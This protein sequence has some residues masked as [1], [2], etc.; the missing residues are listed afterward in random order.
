MSYN[1]TVTKSHRF[2]P[3]TEQAKEFGQISE[4]L[5]RKLATCQQAAPYWV[6]M[7]KAWLVCLYKAQIT[8]K[9]TSEK[10]LTALDKLEGIP[11]Y[12]TE[13]RL[14]DGL[15]MDEKTASVV[16]IGRT[17]QEPMSRLQLRDCLI[18]AFDDLS[19]L[20]KTVIEVAE[21]NIDTI[22]PG[23]THLSHAQPITFAHYLL[24]IFDALQRG[25][26]A[27]ALAYRDTNRNSGGCGACSGIAWPVDRRLMSNL[28][29]FDELLEPTYDSEASQDHSM[30]ILFALANISLLISKSSMDINIWGM[31]EIDFF[32]TS[33]EWCGCSSMMPQKCIP[34]SQ[35]ER[36][37]IQTS[38]VV[39]ELNTGI[40][41]SKGEPHGDML[42]ICRVWGAAL[43]GIFYTQAAIGY[44]KGVLSN[45]TPQKEK[46]LESV[47]EGYSCATELV[48]H[49]VKN[50]G[51]GGRGAHRIVATMVR[52]GREKGLKAYE[53][54]GELLDEAARFSEDKEP[55]IETEL[56]RKLLDPVEFIKTHSNIGGTA[57]QEADR[58]I[59]IRKRKVAELE[60]IQKKR[61]ANIEKGKELLSAQIKDILS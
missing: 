18:E 47:R 5:E 12:N 58:M 22:M 10:L 16:N 54:T 20:M 4:D 46:M 31:E 15:G 29:G 35:A 40:S 1:E 6:K 38:F 55:N 52:M 21:K 39:G 23:Y 36:A 11:G 28:L 19:A 33:Y 17:M 37:R 9:E 53:C 2:C 24:S 57:P 45:I 32:K 59:K 27:L 50:L 3:G 51:Y 48:V 7:D 44:Y 43:R 8:D 30:S 14:M 60:E 42:P 61:K 13:R 56:L 26:D 25:H 49:M 41:L 34:G